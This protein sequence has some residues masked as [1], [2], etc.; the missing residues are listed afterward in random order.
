MHASRSESGTQK[1]L[2]VGIRIIF[3]SEE[4]PMMEDEE[5]GGEIDLCVT[6]PDWIIEDE[7]ESLM[8]IASKKH[9]RNEKSRFKIHSQVFFFLPPFFLL[10]ESVFAKRFRMD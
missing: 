4:P 1:E 9:L 2:S 3:F 10:L 8:V 6:K 7:D 5:Q